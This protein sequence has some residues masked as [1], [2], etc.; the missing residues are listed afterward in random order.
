MLIG[1][2]D[3]GYTNLGLVLAQVDHYKIKHVYF[4]KRI[5]IG[6]YHCKNKDCKVPHTREVC[7]L[8]T[9]FAQDYKQVLD[10]CEIL[11]VERQ[12]PG[13]LGNVEALICYL[14]RPKIHWISPTSMHKHHMISHLD[15]E[16]RKVKTEQIAKK[17]LGGKVDY[18]KEVRKHDMADAMCMIMFWAQP[19]RDEIDRK[20]RQ[21][22]LRQDLNLD[23]FKY[24]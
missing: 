15:Y 12:P 20:K 9:H 19:K 5:N 6:N 22:E 10:S 24:C 7:D 14:F 16:G 13:G 2:I 4:C 1:A 23:R 17:W 18:D 11:L 3:I 8:V 21:Q